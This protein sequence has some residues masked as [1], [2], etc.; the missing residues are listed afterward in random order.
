MFQARANRLYRIMK[1]TRQMEHPRP[2][3]KDMQVIIATRKISETN[4]I[5]M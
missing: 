4:A 5:L 1:Q 3:S 2:A